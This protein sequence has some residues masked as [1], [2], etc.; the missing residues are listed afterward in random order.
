[1][2]VV[3]DIPAETERLLQAEWCERSLAF[4]ERPPV[5]G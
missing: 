5:V 1:M 3:I 2:T 4:N